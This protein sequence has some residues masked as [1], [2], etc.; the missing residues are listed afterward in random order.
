[1][2]FKEI[3][4]SYDF[5]ETKDF[6]HSRTEEDVKRALSAQHPTEG[7]FA[8][9][10]SP[11]AEKY[12]EQ[13]AGE[14]SRI[15]LQRFGKTIKLYAPIYLSNICTNSCT[16]CGF[17]RHNEI[18]RI[19]LTDEE[20]HREAK[21]ISDAGIQHMLL[22]TGESPAQ[23]GVD[24]LINAVKIARNY[25]SS[26][27][28][29]VFPMSTAEYAEL[30]KNGVDGLTIYQETYSRERYAEVHPAGRK[31]DYDWRLETPERGAEA[32]LRTV[33]IGALMGLDD[34]RTEEFFVGLHA[35]YL[36]RK[37]WKTHV[38]VS[39]PRIRKAAGNFVPYQ[40]VSDINLVQSMLAL[41]L[42][43]NDVGL[44]ISTREPADMRDNLLPLGVTQMSAGS[45][46]EPGGYSEENDGKQFEVEDSRTVAEFCDMLRSKGYDPVLKDWD[47]S[48][49]TEV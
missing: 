18:P 21:I 34:F 13:A 19:T 33:G 10:L 8:A 15:T 29:E 43:L 25:F 24:Y 27:S 12:I 30:Y 44:V 38:T 1:M 17:N 47:R 20:I 42:F 11:A 4:K 26:V 28:V 39:F 35:R 49:L 37:Y 5:Q 45:K 40:I 41:R 6:I 23:I 16:Y 22:V 32:G 9:L 36:M 7:D 14:A 2:S 3:L 48:F 31:R 46:T